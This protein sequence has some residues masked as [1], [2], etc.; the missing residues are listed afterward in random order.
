MDYEQY[1]RAN[2]IIVKDDDL[3]LHGTSSNNFLNIRQTGFLKQAI[4]IRNWGNSPN[5]ICFEKY[6]K[7]ENDVVLEVVAKYCRIA[8]EKDNSQEGVILQITG[9]ELKKLGCPILADWNLGLIIGIDSDSAILSIIVECDVPV[10]YLKELKSIP[11]KDLL[12]GR[13]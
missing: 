10:E 1:S 11:F 4:L 13:F 2:P 5:G 7:G 6:V 8:C 3:F 9:K 12:K